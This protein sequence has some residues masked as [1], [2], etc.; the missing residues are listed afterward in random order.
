M[1]LNFKHYGTGGT[2]L[3]ILHG[4]LGSLENWHTIA[5]E[6]SEMGVV[7]TL[8]LRN[9]GRS[10][11][12]DVFTYEA[13]AA[14]VL[15]F[16]DDQEIDSA[17]LLGHSMGGK[18]AMWAA[19]TYPERVQKLISADMGV[20]RYF[21]EHD[22]ILETLQRFPIDKIQSRKEADVVMSQRISDFSVRQFLLKN[23][24]RKPEG[25]F[26][27]RINLPIILKNYENLLL[28]L[29][30][31]LRF[32]KPALFIRGERSPYIREEDIPG[33][34]RHFPR[35]EIRTIPGAGHWLHAE[36]PAEFVRL[37]KEFLV[38]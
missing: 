29:P 37:V 19:G 26:S 15:E 34:R 3:L 31:S 22:E 5:R 36:A 25:G 18:V 11:H 4:L 8:D 35:A 28:P 16:L 23:L 20:K 13:M 30:D 7:F 33:I 2:P 6:L 24:V 27:W 32:E 38:L 1:K 14:D 21:G 12:S 9:H 10:P 17:V